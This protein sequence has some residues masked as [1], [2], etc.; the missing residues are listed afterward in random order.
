VL[1]NGGVAP[2]ALH[3]GVAAATRAAI[4]SRGLYGNGADTRS[5]AQVPTKKGKKRKG[6]GGKTK[7]CQYSLSFR[8]Y[9]RL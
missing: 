5:A 1:G 6:K 3:G 4:N 2:Q 9:F 7:V 8:C